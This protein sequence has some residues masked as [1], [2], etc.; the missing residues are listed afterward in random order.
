MAYRLTEKGTE[1]YQRLLACPKEQF[2]EFGPE[3]IYLLA[4]GARPQEDHEVPL[5]LIEFYK[6]AKLVDEIE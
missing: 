3:Q 1:I 4:I 5:Q 2:T 6:S